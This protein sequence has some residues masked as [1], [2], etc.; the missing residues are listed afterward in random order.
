MPSAFQVDHNGR[1]FIV[2]DPDSDLDYSVSS[3]LEGLV[4]TAAEWSIEP[5]VAGAL[6]SQS[7]NGAPVVIDGVT[8]QAGELATTWIKSLAAGQDYDVKLRATFTGSRIDERTF[9]VLCR[10]R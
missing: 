8:W 1:R 6:H 2:A 10:Q 4:F 3:W 9:R 5:V 7:I